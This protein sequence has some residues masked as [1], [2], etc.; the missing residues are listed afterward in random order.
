MG[1]DLSV[2]RLKLV[3]DYSINIC[4][5]KVYGIEQADKIFD[6]FIGGSTVEKLALLCLDKHYTPINISLVSIGTKDNVVFCIDEIL[7]IALLSNSSYIIICHNHPSGNL[8]ISELD[9]IQ[10]KKIG[11]VCKLVGIELIDS[12][13]IGDEGR[14]I[15]I[16]A[17]IKEGV[18][19]ANGK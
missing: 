15:S 1:K 4:N 11:Q 3:K 9:I 10:T 7:R 17:Y 18:S 14:S 5:E 6:S 12:L 8:S 2:V 16:R 13:I 19:K